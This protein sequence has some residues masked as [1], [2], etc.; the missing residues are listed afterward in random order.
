MWILLYAILNFHETKKIKYFLLAFVPPLIHV[1]YFALAFPIWIVLLSGYR[2]PKIYFII[3]IVSMLVSNFVAQVGF[4]E[5][6]SQTEVG[7]SKTQAYYVDDEVAERR[8]SRIEASASKARFYKNFERFGLHIK[9]L[10]GLIIFI[11]VFLRQGGFGKIEN[12]LFSYGLAMGAFANFFTQIF[13]VYNR[14]WEISGV[15][16]LSLVVIFLKVYKGILISKCRVRRCPSFN[17]SHMFI[18][19][20]SSWSRHN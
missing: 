2:N 6:A 11:F 5:F 7:A 17:L 10:S 9:V 4:N 3:F 16:I 20:N 15:L 19:S 8:S 18:R 1:G 14:G 12:T 13:A